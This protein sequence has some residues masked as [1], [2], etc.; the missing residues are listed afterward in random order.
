MVLT[1]NGDPG[2]TYCGGE[3]YVTRRN[4]AGYVSNTNCSPCKGT[5]LYVL[6][7]HMYGVSTTIGQ[8]VWVS[9]WSGGSFWYG[10]RCNDGVEYSVADAYMPIPA[11]V[12]FGDI[13][14]VVGKPEVRENPSRV[15][16]VYNLISA[17]KGDR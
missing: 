14:H 11:N 4:P 13:V 17:F 7:F 6:P 9:G 12:R 8:I 2:C 5:G 15:D 16:G 1:P 3:G 10:I